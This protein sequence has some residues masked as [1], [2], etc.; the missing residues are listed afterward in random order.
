MLTK[1]FRENTTDWENR[2]GDLVMAAEYTVIEKDKTAG[3]EIIVNKLKLAYELVAQ[4]L[5]NSINDEKTNNN[6]GIRNKL[7]EN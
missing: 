1:T 7:K 2:M 3:M 6:N 4:N 5:I